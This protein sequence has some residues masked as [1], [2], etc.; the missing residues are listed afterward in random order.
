MRDSTLIS[1]GLRR[2]LRR[3]VHATDVDRRGAAPPWVQAMWFAATFLLVIAVTSSA[4][5]HTQT[6]LDPDDSEGPLDTV[7]VRHQPYKLHA[8]T[9][10]PESPIHVIRLRL[11]TYETWSPEVLADARNFISFE[12]NRDRDPNIER[13]LVIKGSA[14]KLT[15]Q[16]FKNCTYLNDAPVT[17]PTEA[18]RGGDEHGV[19]ASIG[20]RLVAGRSRHRYTW[21]SVTSYEDAAQNSPCPAP[22]PHADGG[23]GTCTDFTRWKTYRF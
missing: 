9:T 20:R 21:R 13:C 1:G 17:R 22:T 7:A 16:L 3:L 6:V 18:F 5:A 4:V 12:F 23:Y 19:E 2:R 15:A 8:T 14:D 10:H 11:V